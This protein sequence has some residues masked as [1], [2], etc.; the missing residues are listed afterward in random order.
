M[1]K[2]SHCA[3]TLHTILISK[4]SFDV[5]VK[6]P[7]IASTVAASIPYYPVLF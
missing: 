3:L 1:G 4:L 6:C 2:S 7:L 5:A